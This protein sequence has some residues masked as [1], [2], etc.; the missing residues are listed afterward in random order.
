MRWKL[1]GRARCCPW[2]DSLKGS[3]QRGNLLSLNARFLL[4][5]CGDFLGRIR[6]KDNFYCVPHWKLLSLILGVLK[7]T[8]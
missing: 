3:E 4:A 1:E 6:E 7:E 8:D 5:H 2:G